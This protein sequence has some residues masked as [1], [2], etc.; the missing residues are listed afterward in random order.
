MQI[1]YNPLEVNEIVLGYVQE[2]LNLDDSNDFHVNVGEDGSITVLVNEDSAGQ[3]PESGNG[4]KIQSAE[5][6]QRRTRRTKAQIEADEAEEAA[7]KAAAT[8]AE[9]GKQEPTPLEKLRAGDLVGKETGNAVPESTQTSSAEV[10]Q[11]SDNAVASAVSEEPVTETGSGTNSHGDEPPIEAPEEPEAQ[12]ESE[13][14]VAK[15]P[16]P[17]TEAPTRPAGVS[18]FANLRKQTNS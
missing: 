11:V 9:Q 2:K 1:I 12:V 13:P 7:K 10:A 16:E 18:L 3:Q 6:P 17:A 14:E 4:E 15:N 8:E 5:K